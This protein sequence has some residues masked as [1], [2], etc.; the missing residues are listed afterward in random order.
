M[1]RSKTPPVWRRLP[2]EKSVRL[3]RAS[4]IEIEPP[5]TG[6]ASIISA[7]TTPSRR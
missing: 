7:N 4:V 1:A 5:S 6:I 3:T 2:G